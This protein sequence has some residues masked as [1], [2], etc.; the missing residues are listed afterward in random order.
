MAW[1]AERHLKPL[2]FLLWGQGWVVD[3]L[4]ETFLKFCQMLAHGKDPTLIWVYFKRE[5]GLPLLNY[6]EACFSRMEIRVVCRIGV[7][8]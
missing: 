8:N 3:D 7:K 4:V 1:T 5:S 6:Q 2:I